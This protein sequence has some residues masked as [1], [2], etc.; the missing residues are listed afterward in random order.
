MNIAWTANELLYLF[1]GEMA[2]GALLVI[3]LAFS[4]KGRAVELFKGTNGRLLLKIVTIFFVCMITGN[5]ALIRIFD[6]AVVAALL[7]AV[8]GYVFGNGAIS[9]INTHSTGQDDDGNVVNKASQ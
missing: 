2:L 1:L 9:R 3:A 4:L 5:L 8:L 6:P 7:G